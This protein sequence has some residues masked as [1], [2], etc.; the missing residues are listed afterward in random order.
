VSPQKDGAVTLINNFAGYLQ[1][2]SFKV[3]WQES[4]GRIVRLFWQKMK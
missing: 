2:H 3:T 1:W 4:I